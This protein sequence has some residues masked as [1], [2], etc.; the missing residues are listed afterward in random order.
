MSIK[1]INGKYINTNTNK[2]VFQISFSGG[3]TSG[4]MTKMLLD[5]YSEKYDFLVVFA[6]TGM[7]HEKTLEFV[8]NCDKYFNFNTVWLEAKVN[9]EN[10]KGTTFKI[11]N[12]ETAS[13]NGEPYEAVMA[14]YGIP[15]VAYPHCTRELKMQP[16]QAYTRSLGMSYSKIKTAIGIRNDETRRVSKKADVNSIVYP[17]VDWFPVD[18]QDVNEWWSEQ[19]FDLGLEDY[20]GNCKGCFKKSFKKIFT[21]IDENSE[22]LKNYYQRWETDFGK[23]KTKE[24][25]G[26]RV[27]FRGNISAFTL[28][29][30]YESDRASDSPIKISGVDM[31]SNSGCSE[32]C[33]MYP[34]N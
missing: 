7:E 16:I 8:N 29:E 1:E 13:R 26:G 6:N 20:N 17:L 24:E 9:M 23:V 18:K 4:Y 28:Q 5:N 14:K 34:T 15:N 25:L 22:L 10:G 2:E 30:M 33:E 19:E 3:R 12:F 31:D 11:V 32:S 27:F 21:Q